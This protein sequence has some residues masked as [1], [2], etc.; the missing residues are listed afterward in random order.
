MSK[1]KRILFSLVSILLIGLV[2]FAVST[3]SW[4]RATKRSEQ[5]VA[6]RK[7]TSK[8]KAEYLRR[9]TL[10][11]RLAWGLRDFGDRFEKPGNERV[12]IVG[13]FQAA[14][15][16]AVLLVTVINE[17]PQRARL[18]FEDG[19]RRQ[20]IV[21]NHGEVKTTTPPTDVQQSLLE[22]VANDSVEHF[23]WTQIQGQATSSLGDKYRLDEGSSPTYD[24][25]YYDV[26]QLMDESNLNSESQPVPKFFYFNAST[27]L[28]ERVVYQRFSEDASK[29]VEVLFKDW[30]KQNGQSVPF[31]IERFE[32]GQRVFVFT[33]QSVGFGPRVSEDTFS[34]VTGN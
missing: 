8:E 29:R 32:N 27:H 12:S 14:S 23:F 20:T 2:V 25:P 24:G 9:S 16:P 28:L 26:Y 31:R 1:Q 5:R 19:G 18:I 3:N 13:A 33:V 15:D 22:A 30:R 34:S 7:S 21:F 10:K 11:P 17:F 6:G 4:R